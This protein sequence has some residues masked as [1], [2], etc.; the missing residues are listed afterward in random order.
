M[1]EPLRVQFGPGLEA[2][3]RE[4]A[5]AVASNRG[6]AHEP[7]KDGGF[8]LLFSDHLEIW[9]VAMATA[10]AWREAQSRRGGSF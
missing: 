5:I 4:I 10:Q 3:R 9:K 6:V 1:S 7:R 2:W 8:D